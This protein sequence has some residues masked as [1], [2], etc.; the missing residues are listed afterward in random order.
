MGWEHAFIPAT[1]N[2][3]PSRTGQPM[4]RGATCLAVANSRVRPV[5]V[6]V[7]GRGNAFHMTE[8]MWNPADRT[9]TITGAL[10]HS[11]LLF[12]HVYPTYLPGGCRTPTAG[13]P[14]CCTRKRHEHVPCG[15]NRSWKHVRWLASLHLQLSR[16]R[17]S[18]A[19]L[20]T[21]HECPKYT[22][23]AGLQWTRTRSR[24]SCGELSDVSTGQPAKASST[25]SDDDARLVGT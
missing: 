18:H 17:T 4:P 22:S 19:F 9:R 12:Q 5:V 16:S 8:R 15:H 20:H 7:H 24:R 1:Q 2:T 14:C 13:L 11:M 21:A 3:S 10:F 23:A 6:A 25:P